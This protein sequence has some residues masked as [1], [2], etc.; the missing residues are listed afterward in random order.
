[1][2]CGSSSQRL[3]RSVREATQPAGSA[4]PRRGG[5]GDQAVSTEDDGRLQLPNLLNDFG[6]LVDLTALA[7]D[8]SQWLDAFLLAAGVNQIVEDYLHPDPL[9]ARKVARHAGRL[10]QPL[11]A[12]AATAILWA[13]ATLAELHSREPRTRDWLDW[14]ARWARLVQALAD[15]A[16]GRHPTTVAEVLAVAEKLVAEAHAAPPG[17]RRDILRLP[18]CFRSFDQ[19][20]A[21]LEQIAVH[22]AGRWPDRRRP[23][24]VVGLR[25]SGSYLAPLYAALLKAA[26]YGSVDAI[27][28]RPGRPLLAR[29]RRR[30]RR[31]ASGGGLALL[32]DDPPTSGGSFLAAGAALERA[33]FATQ[34]IVLLL[35]L[36]GTEQDVPAG[37]S[38][39]ARVV[40]PWAE[41]AVHEQL[42]PAA[43]QATI[44][45]LLGP[46]TLVNQVES[47][48][49]RERTGR[50]GH[51]QALYA[52]HC[53][54][55]GTGRCYTER[56]Y[57]R[58]AGLGYFGAHALVVARPLEAYL[59]RIYGLRR[60]VLYRQWLAEERQLSTMHVTAPEAQQAVADAITAY[61]LA[62]GRA[63]PVP[64]DLSLRLIDREPVWQVAGYLL[65]RGFG[66]GAPMAR[67]LLLRAAQ[68]LLEV[69]RPSV[70]DGSTGLSRWF[71]A[72]APGSL[73][74][75][76]KVDFDER[77]FSNLDY[78]C[79]D[80]V[81]D[82]AGA[83]GTC[84]DQGLWSA[85]RRTYERESGERIEPERWLLY[86]VVQLEDS[87]R[88][89]VE[90]AL[91]VEHACARAL[92]RY[93]AETL[94]ADTV[95]ARSGPL[96]MIDI[97]GV[98]ET[99][100]LGFPGL[101][102]AGALALRA[103]TRHGF[104]SVLATGRSLGEVGERCQ[105][106]ALAGGVA[107][108]GAVVLD[109]LG[110]GVR[111]LLAPADHARLEP[112]RAALPALAGVY[113]DPECRYSVRAYR[114]GPYGERY[115]LEPALSARILEEHDTEG[116]VRAIQGQAQTDFMVV[117]ID[118]GA[119][120]R[121]L[122]ELLGADG[123]GPL[124]AIGDSVSDLPVLALARVARAPANADA[125]VR[126]S[127][128]RLLRRPFQLGFVDA[129]SELLGHSPGRCATCAPPR[130]DTTTR[131]LLGV[132]GAQDA[133]RWGKL[134]E[135]GLLAGRLVLAD[136][137]AALSQP[138]GGG[139][140][141]AS[142]AAR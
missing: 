138:G 100:Q 60:G 46:S 38:S 127:G 65:G 132:L 23:L 107:E 47:L 11:G 131:L 82:Q 125:A 55:A 94:F 70:V 44:A 123:P 105:A 76:L 98:L 15:R 1:M 9:S 73:R 142:D 77:A 59:P 64:E 129:V 14:Q 74:A 56:V 10:R 39:Y 37:L 21:D 63:L 78:A 16:T 45:E 18:S 139:V 103:L 51:V 2:R 122:L 35:P 124:F 66:R 25:T 133:W 96:C 91:A 108:Y 62:R 24:V 106:Y 40:L 12:R 20:P 34:A 83:A 116:R 90:R 48:P 27:T 26:G 102:P 95:P 30:L 22:F 81:Y 141:R 13:G 28:L 8:R 36:F 54:E 112:I 19:Q 113:L 87:V 86:Q 85:L 32:A 88:T 69:H 31:L 99:D 33:G 84:A 110:G 29:E 137:V 7:V 119:G 17:L 118:K 49:L 58:G 101:T 53:Q 80:P 50:R 72:D 3:Q 109:Q 140:G 120:T 111:E 79:F 43:V 68:R 121:A 128:V 57:A 117:G 41:W 97:D 52:A 134:R 5:D 104:R 135:F 114:L 71:A 115:G 61:V 136:C 130:L 93:F 89:R 6:T 67:P 126:Q 42:G 75:L 4:D 92:Q